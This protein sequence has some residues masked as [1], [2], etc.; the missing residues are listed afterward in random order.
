MRTPA[1]TLTFDLAPAVA[2]IAVALAAPGARAET[3][4]QKGLAIARKVDQ[5]NEGF[6]SERATMELE[7]VN[8]HGDTT[9]R[10]MTN[11]ILEGK[12]DGDKS[13]T[14]IEW[15]ADL[16]GTKLLTFTHKRGEDDQWLYMPATKR[17]KRISS[18]NKSGSFMGSEFAYEDLGSQEVEKYTYKFLEEVKENGRDAWRMERFPVDKASGYARQIIVIDKEYMLPARIEYFDRKNEL[19]KLAVFS[20]FKRHG[21]WWKIGKIAVTNVQTKKRSV[22]TWTNRELGVKLDAARFDSATLEDE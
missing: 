20:D 19:L 3:A 18:N 2:A 16:K 8:A 15:P 22:L 21:K 4:E 1:R 9:R 17:V 5:A 13:K 7:L 6:V 12:D 11:E 14:V 10:R